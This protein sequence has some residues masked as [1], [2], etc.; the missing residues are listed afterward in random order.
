MK[1]SN[2]VVNWCWFFWF[3]DL[4]QSGMG[5]PCGNAGTTAGCE[6]AV[7]CIH[8]KGKG[9]RGDA[10]ARGS[11]PTTERPAEAVDRLVE[12][13]TGVG[14][15]HPQLCPEPIPCRGRELLAPS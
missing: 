7:G 1:F 12:A 6:P 4:T 15:I 9:Q 3:G 8:T 13:H 5:Q 2:I 11:L 14:A 10:M